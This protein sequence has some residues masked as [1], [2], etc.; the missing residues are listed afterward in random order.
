MGKAARRL[1][2][3]ESIWL[4]VYLASAVGRDEIWAALWVMAMIWW[5]ALDAVGAILAV[6][7]LVCL[8][9]GDRAARAGLIAAALLPLATLGL[10]RAVG[11]DRV[12][13]ARFWVER[14]RY[15]ARVDEIL[16]APV[17]RR[18][19]L[20]GND[21]R[22]DPGPPLRVAFVLPGGILDHWTAVVYDPTGRVVA[23][24]RPLEREQAAGSPRM[25]FG[26]LMTHALPL[27]G[28]WYRC[29]FT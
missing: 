15:Q 26:G 13:V 14:G 24:N 22:L 3:A 19:A 18:A 9:R 16:A 20:A 17:A 27:G 10:V 1:L 2:V 12:A 6:V 23:S 25:L 4:A 28:P 21:C 8:I 5:G 7:A 29:W 11:P